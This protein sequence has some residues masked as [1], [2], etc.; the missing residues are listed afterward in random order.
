MRI[1]I[2]LSLISCGS[3]TFKN[4][5]READQFQFA[6]S[7]GYFDSY[8]ADFEADLKEVTG[9]NINTNLIRINFVPNL[10][11]NE[12]G[13]CY[14]WLSNAEI[15]ISLNYWQSADNNSRKIL[16][17]HELGHCALKLEHNNGKYRNFKYSIM[18][19]SVLPGV[20][21]DFFRTGLMRELFTG[22]TS[23]ISQE[24]N[25]FLR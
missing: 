7:N 24:I 22:D 14:T 2:L 3:L 16:I 21:L 5:V 23:L 19:E 18:D 20:Y 10:D 12:V 8:K 1:L 17:Y 15:V 9:R 4:D 6:S 25:E 11:G 13:I